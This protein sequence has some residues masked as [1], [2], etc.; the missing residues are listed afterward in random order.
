[1][2]IA[3]ASLSKQ[4]AEERKTQMTKKNSGAT[5][6]SFFT[7][8]AQDALKGGVNTK[9]EAALVAFFLEAAQKAI[10]K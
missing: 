9:G 4:M 3:F 2:A 1:M 8:C 7:A 6:A 5:L 10:G